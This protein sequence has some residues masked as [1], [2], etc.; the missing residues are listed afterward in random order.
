MARFT[1]RQFALGQFN[2]PFGEVASSLT[3]LFDNKDAGIGPERDDETERG[4]EPGRDE[5][6]DE[7]VLR[8][9]RVFQTVG[10]YDLVVELEPESWRKQ[11]RQDDRSW[12]AFCQ[13]CCP[14][15]PPGS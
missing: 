8:K 7:K 4:Q 14:F 1:G 9:R 12:F 2:L 10:P 3:T 15:I 6:L 11:R 5:E 13:P